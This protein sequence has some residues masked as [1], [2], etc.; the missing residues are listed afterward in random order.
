MKTEIGPEH[1]NILET[2]ED[3]LPKGAVLFSGEETGGPFGD[4]VDMPE[5][6]DLRGTFGAGTLTYESID[7]GTL[8]WDMEYVKVLQRNGKMVFIGMAAEVQ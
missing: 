3:V 2:L 4:P 8:S 1:Y 7:G 5:G 6:A